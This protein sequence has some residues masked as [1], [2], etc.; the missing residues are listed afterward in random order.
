VMFSMCTVQP[1][2]HGPHVAPELLKRS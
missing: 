2:I 1:S